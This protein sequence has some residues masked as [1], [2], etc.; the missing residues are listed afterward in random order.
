M[1]PKTVGSVTYENDKGEKCFALVVSEDGDKY[2]LAVLDPETYTLTAA[3][4]VP[5]D[6]PRVS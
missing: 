3:N 2:N 1:T 5:K 6:S 4:S